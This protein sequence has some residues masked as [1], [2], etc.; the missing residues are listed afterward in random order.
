[1]ESR[2]KTGEKGALFE[3]LPSMNFLLKHRE[4]KK[5]VYKYDKNHQFLRFAIKNAWDKPNKY[6]F[7]TDISA[8]YVAAVF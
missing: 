4:E 7:L 3:I 6:Y 1:M 2:A 5:V 8:V